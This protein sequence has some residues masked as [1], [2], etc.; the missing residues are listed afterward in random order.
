MESAS[1]SGA[2]A[3]AGA[4]FSFARTRRPRSS[5]RA[6]RRALVAHGHREA[7]ARAC[8]AREEAA[9]DPFGRIGAIRNGAG[10]RSALGRPGP[11]EFEEADWP[12]GESRP[13]AA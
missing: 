2:P 3:R 12:K 13:K 1:H 6:Q 4:P 7:G 5:A 10:T 9:P 8:A 11:A